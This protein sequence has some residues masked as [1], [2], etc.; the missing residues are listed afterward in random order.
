MTVDDE[1][2]MELAMQALLDSVKPMI[3]KSKKIDKPSDKDI[4]AEWE[5]WARFLDPVNDSISF[6]I[7]QRKDGTW[8]ITDGGEA[9]G[10]NSLYD[11]LPEDHLATIAK[12]IIGSYFETKME[13]GELYIDF[14]DFDSF[15]DKFQE[16]VIEIISAQLRVY[17]IGE[18]VKEAMSIDWIGEIPYVR[19]K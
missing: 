15:A 9:W 18:L 6:Y 8:R 13:G 19:K 14:K 5:V 4:V 3:F 17:T 10:E 1:R 16:A 12:K 7:E 11:I 2:T